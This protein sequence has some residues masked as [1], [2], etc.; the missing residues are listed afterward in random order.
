MKK[1][2]YLIL[3]IAALTL[4]VA[5]N[6][7]SY[8]KTKSGLVYKIFPSGSNDSLLKDGQIVKFNYSMKFN[9]SLLYTSYGKLPAYQRV[10]PMEKPPYNLLEI[11]TLMKKG[12]SAVTVQMVDTL[13]KRGEQLP[14]NAKKGDR[15]TTTVRIINVFPSDSIAMKD[16]NIE[17]EKD[18]PR[19]MKEQEEQMAKM[20]K[21]RKEQQAKEEIELQK[22]GEIAKELQA[23]ETYL[24]GKKI[25]AQKTG[26]GTYVYIQQQG[27]GPIADSGKYVNVKYTGKHL[28]TD[29]T[30]QSNSYAFQLGVGGV[31]QGWDEG[32]KLFKQ[33]GKGTLYVPGFLS[34]GKNP[35]TGSP[36]KP[37]EPLKFDIELLEVSDKPIAQR[38]GQ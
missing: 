23:M 8:R 24:A 9:D 22:S 3:V 15:I 37:F 16:Y 10:Q 1:V 6:K 30:F 28:D 29:S 7:I 19:Q 34:Y 33:G 38:Q 2:N 26:K 5:C 18:R 17:A 35:P 4:T 32:L 11:L 21:E 27:T 31:I 12:D 13:M 20:Q 14:P 25:N 36:F